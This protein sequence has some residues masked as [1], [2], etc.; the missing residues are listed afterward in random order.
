MSQALH[1]IY[2]YVALGYLLL[3]FGCWYYIVRGQTQ[4]TPRAV[5]WY[6]IFSLNVAI[7]G[8]IT[9]RGLPLLFKGQIPHHYSLIITVLL[10]CFIVVSRA[11][12]FGNVIIDALVVAAFIV[13][14]ASTLPLGIFVFITGSTNW[15]HLIP[16]LMIA[17]LVIAISIRIYVWLVT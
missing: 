12:L 4:F 9:I 1:N 11:E 8:I 17:T 10:T 14:I 7:V 13:L 6:M 5:L 15:P 2:L 3:L 16:V